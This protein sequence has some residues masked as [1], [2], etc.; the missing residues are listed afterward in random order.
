MPPPYAGI[1]KIA[2]L[3][4]REWRKKGHEVALTFTYRPK[5][6][7]E[8]GANSHYFFEYTKRPG[9]LEKFLFLIRYFFTN[10]A[11]YIE[12]FRSYRAICPHITREMYLYT[13]YGVYLDRVYTAFRPDVVLSE[14]VLIKTFMAAKIAKR[15]GVPIM[16]NVYAEVRDM[17]M[18]ENRHLT[19][20]QRKT[21]WVSFLT[22]ADL[23][24]GMANCSVEMKAYIPREKLVAFWDPDD[25]EV[26]SRPVAE[27]KEELR[28]HFNLPA[29][30]FLAC[31]VG[32]FELRKGHDHLIR[33]VANVAK[34]GHDVGVAI[35]G[36]LGSN[37]KWRAIAKEEGVEGRAFFF[38]SLSEPE[39][40]KLLNCVDV[41]T[42]LSNTQ[43]CCGLDMGLL[44]GMA[45]RLPV[46]VYDTGALPGAV[47]NGENG[48]VVPMNEIDKV[49]EAIVKLM[50]KTPE[51]RRTMGEKS[52]EVAKGRDIKLYADIRLRWFAEMVQKNT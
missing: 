40:V 18:G 31:A 8:L 35:C 7:D 41:N 19:E 11:L 6:A 42:N 17:G 52:A 14:A 5:N 13:A 32:S 21:Y 43:R 38:N 10:P 15:H 45:A 2:L 22:M 29:S 47:P 3:C 44:E 36:S 26:Y 23:V 34:A 28:T 12:L 48:Y 39:L 46:I 1:P 37:E 30:A 50:Q 20:D 9:K 27:S 25:Y 4:A 24:I 51:E 49:S 16:F 33:A